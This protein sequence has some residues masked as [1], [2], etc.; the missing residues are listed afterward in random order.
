MAIPFYLLPS[1]DVPLLEV[2]QLGFCFKLTWTM[3]IFSP[4]N[5]LIKMVMVPRRLS[6]VQ[7]QHFI[8]SMS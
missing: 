7:Y 8:A 4:F 2:V 1:T 5:L 6:A 3:A